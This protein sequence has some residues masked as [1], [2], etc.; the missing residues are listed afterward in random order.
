MLLSRPTAAI[1][2]IKRIFSGINLGKTLS[3]YWPNVTRGVCSAFHLAVFMYFLLSKVVN[4]DKVSVFNV[5][6]K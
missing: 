1:G 2:S 6:N 3:G 4:H 5:F